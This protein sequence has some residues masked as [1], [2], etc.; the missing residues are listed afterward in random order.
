LPLKKF[1][2]PHKPFSRVEVETDNVHLVKALI[3]VESSIAVTLRVKI[4]AMKT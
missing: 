1:F 4:E 3:L 2:S